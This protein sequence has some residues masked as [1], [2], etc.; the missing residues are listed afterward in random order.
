MLPCTGINK[1]SN[2]LLSW[3]KRNQGHHQLM[4]QSHHIP[5]PRTG[6]SWAVLNKNRT[7]T[8][9]RRTNFASPYGVRRAC[10]ISLR[11][12]YGF[13]VPKKP[14]NSSC[15]ARMDPVRSNMTPVWEFCQ[16][17]LCQFPY[18]SVRLSYGTLEG[19]AWTPH[20]SRWI[21]KTL[22]I[23]VRGPRV[24]RTDTARGTRGVLRIIQPNHKCSAVSN[25]TGP[26]A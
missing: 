22:K 16:F 19:P 4:P 26:V 10:I 8:H 24:A 21:W 20:G 15:G 25:R 6:C 3:A 2:T 7:S 18:V 14:G 11:A 1:S 5:G 23:H 17:W 12:P 9:G 13:R